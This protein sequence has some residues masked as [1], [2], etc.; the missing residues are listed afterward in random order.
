MNLGWFF[1]L[2]LPYHPVD[3]LN[4]METENT[5]TSSAGHKNS[6]KARTQDIF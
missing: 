5:L 1:F 3:I 4:I 2:Y 6:R